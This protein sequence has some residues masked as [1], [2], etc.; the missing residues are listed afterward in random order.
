MLKNT[1]LNYN[2]IYYNINMQDK[3]QGG[4][5]RDLADPREI[6][7]F[8]ISVI[9]TQVWIFRVAEFDSSIFK[10]Q[11]GTYYQLGK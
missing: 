7:V 4:I 5:F 9:Y 1:I 6:I 2:C 10:L 11:S 8:L 3:L